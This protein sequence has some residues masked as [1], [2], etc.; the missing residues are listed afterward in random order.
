[1]P[2]AGGVNHERAHSVDKKNGGGVLDTG[3]LDDIA[4]AKNL[5]L[6]TDGGVRHAANPF[7]EFNVG[8]VF[9]CKIY[10]YYNTKNS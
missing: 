6:V 3:V 9:I 1:M 8:Y 4:R 7:L 2:I 10:Q 5:L